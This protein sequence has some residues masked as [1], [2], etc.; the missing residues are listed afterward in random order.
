M[1]ILVGTCRVNDNPAMSSKVRISL[2]EQFICFWN[3]IMAFS[4]RIQTNA[5]SNGNC[6]WNIKLNYFVYNPTVIK[7]IKTII[8]LSFVIKMKRCELYALFCIV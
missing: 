7:P 1:S 8:P 2:I 5:N 4:Y 6:I 3:K